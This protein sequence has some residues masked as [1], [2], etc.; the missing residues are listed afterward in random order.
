MLRAKKNKNSM[1]NIIMLQLNKF[2]DTHVRRPWG[3][4]LKQIFRD[5][6]LYI[7]NI[8]TTKLW[9]VGGTWQLLQDIMKSIALKINTL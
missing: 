6:S 3:D 1:E 7:T 5:F 4:N 2:Y 9:E 8:Q